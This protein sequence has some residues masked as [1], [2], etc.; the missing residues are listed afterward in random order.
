MTKQSSITGEVLLLCERLEIAQ[1]MHAYLRFLFKQGITLPNMQIINYQ[2]FE[3]L[4]ALAQRLNRLEGSAQVSKVLF[5]ADADD[6]QSERQQIFFAVRDAAF[7]AKVKACHYF[8]FLGRKPNKRWQRG[9][10]E[11]A[12]WQALEQETAEY[13]DFYNLHNMSEEYLLLVNNNRGREHRLQNY[14][15]HLLYTYFAATEKYVGL[16]LGEAA[17]AGAFDLHHR[18]FDSLRECLCA[19][20][21]GEKE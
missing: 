10:L 18:V 20:Q 13:N 12:L 8:F 16:R 19:L 11:D 21:I 7:F 9:Y 1:F 17:L 2:G 15:R 6:K 14:R 3:K 4:P 5:L